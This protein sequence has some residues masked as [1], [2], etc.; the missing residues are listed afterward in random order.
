[1]PSGMTG[2]FGGNSGY[3]AASL[4]IVLVIRSSSEWNVITLIR[5]FTASISIAS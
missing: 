5:P 3:D 2:K 1:M 4:K